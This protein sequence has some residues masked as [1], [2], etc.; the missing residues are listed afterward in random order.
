[1]QHKLAFIKPVRWGLV[2]LSLFLMIAIGVAYTSGYK[3]ISDARQ[4][5]RFADYAEAE[6]ILNHCWRLPGLRHAIELETQLL[7]VQQGDLR[8]ES[9]LKDAAKKKSPDSQAILEALARGYLATFRSNDAESIA[10]LLVDQDGTNAIAFWVRGLARAEMQQEAL[11]L[12]DLEKALELQPT[13]VAIRRSLAK[14]LQRQGYIRQ[15]FDHLRI[16]F[17]QCPSDARVV[18]GIVQCL[19]DEARYDDARSLADR[20]VIEHP[21]FVPGLVESA[22]IAVRQKDFLTAESNLRQATR[23]LPDHFEANYLWRTL[24]QHEHINDDLHDDLIKKLE[25]QQANLKKRQRELPKQPQSLV[26]IGQW[27]L[28]TGQDEEAGGWFYLSLQEDPDFAPAHLG[29]MEWYRQLGQPLRSHLHAR[30]GGVRTV[31]NS[32]PSKPAV[33]GTTQPPKAT[34]IPEL[35]SHQ[36]IEASE[37]QVRS[38]CAA[39]HAYPDPNTMPRSA[40]RKE[41]QQGFSFL[42]DSVMSGEHPSL[43]SVVMYY[44]KSAPESWTPIS[45]SAA[46]THSPFQFE[47]R[48]TGWMPNQPLPPGITN[49]NL[50]GLLGGATKELVLSDVRLDLLMVLRPYDNRPGGI[51]IPQVSSP[52]HTTVCDLDAD[53][54]QDIL[55]ASIGSFFPT[56]DKLGKLLWLRATAPG[57]FDAVTIAEDLGRLVDVQAADFNGDGRLDLVAAVFGWRAGGEILYLENQTTDWSKPMFTRRNVDSRHGTIHVPIV[58]LNRDGRPDFVS[59][60]SQEH[61]MVTAYLNQGEGEFQA[62]PLFSAE[63]PTFGCSGIEIVD[64]DGDEDS[65]VILTNGDVLDPP[66]LLKPYHG[67]HWLENEGRYPFTAHRLMAMNGVARAVTADFDSDGDLDVLAT[68][69]LPAMQFPDREKLQLPSVVLLEQQSGKHFEPHI[70]EQGTCDHYSCSAG[71]WDNDGDVDFAVANFA[72]NGSLAISDAATLWRNT[73]KR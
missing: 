55:V 61:E 40:W 73:K 57:K 45:H 22:R 7:A 34:G 71:D 51:V 20:L 72:W 65:D 9:L 12:E 41:V 16:L 17:S 11:A 5:R 58:D 44:E 67:I 60:T 64:L 56:N 18:L 50:A 52:C 25:L 14:Q 46:M 19:Q 54:I 8:H 53:G 1:L 30:L 10:Q 38:L 47:K 36:V 68:S 4:A 31:G 28:K 6:A 70:V 35:P 15:A 69:F 48:G 23:L 21:D 63:N 24:R 26:D 13:A 27:M 33:V 2:G 29:L 43:E 37:A 3:W 62:V 39:C 49:I 59:L 32:E 66:Y 42:H